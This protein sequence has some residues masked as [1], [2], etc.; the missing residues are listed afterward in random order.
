MRLEPVCQNTDLCEQLPPSKKQ[1]RTV[2]ADKPQSRK[3]PASQASVEGLHERHSASSNAAA[4][5]PDVNYNSMRTLATA[6]DTR[7][8]QNEQTQIVGVLLAANK[9]TGQRISSEECVSDSHLTEHRSGDLSPSMSSSLV[10]SNTAN[11]TTGGLPTAEHSTWSTSQIDALAAVALA[12]IDYD[13][14]VVPQ[15]DPIVAPSS[16][17]RALPEFRECGGDPM[18]SGQPD[19]WVEHGNAASGHNIDL[20]L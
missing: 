17:G 2:Q 16:Q 15:H 9:E 20:V 11:R 19:F 18:I 1:K 6:R 7:S 5:A 14:Y 12:Q 13:A 3:K 8:A 4:A 10:S